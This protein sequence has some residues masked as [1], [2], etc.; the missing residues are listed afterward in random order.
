[1]ADEPDANDAGVDEIR[2]R[3]LDHIRDRGHSALVVQYG[4]AVVVLLESSG[5]SRPL[6]EAAQVQQ[7]LDPL[8]GGPARLGIGVGRSCLAATDYAPGYR[9]ARFA[10]RV[11]GAQEMGPVVAVDDLG[12]FSAFAHVVEDEALETAVEG[13][14]APLR[15]ERNASKVADYMATIE[16]FL[17]NN[18]NLENTAAQLHIHVNTLRYRLNKIQSLL[19]VDLKDAAQRFQLELALRLR[20]HLR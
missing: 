2:E 3:A 11:S 17:E 12:L 10:A 7:L 9:E 8:R 14:F 6:T 15:G 4:R 13:V 18:L 16:A 5:N 19:H 1:M 20:R